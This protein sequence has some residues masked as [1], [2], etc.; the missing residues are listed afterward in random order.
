[1]T[2]ILARLKKGREQAGLS[3]GQASFLLNISRDHVKEL[4]TYSWPDDERLSVEFGFTKTSYNDILDR[5][6][7]VYGVKREW[8]FGE[9]TALDDELIQQLQAKFPNKADKLIELLESIQG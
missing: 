3:L 1:M 7:K 9:E 5:M 6:A 8:F 2:V 4:E